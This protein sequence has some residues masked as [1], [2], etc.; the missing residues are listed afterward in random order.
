MLLPSGG[1]KGMGLA[2]FVEVLAGSLTGNQPGKQGSGKIMP[3]EF[4]GFLLILNPELI[5]GAEYA[6]HIA[7]WI[8]VYLAASDGMRLPGSRA[9]QS[10]RERTKSGIPIAPGVFA[11]LAR[12]ADK[13]GVPRLN[14]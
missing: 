4:G 14:S 13:L 12:V 5:A 1:H 11:D 6:P 10:E 7:D 3:P 2:M 8:D 9:D